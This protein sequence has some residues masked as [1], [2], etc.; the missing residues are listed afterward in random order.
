MKLEDTLAN[1]LPG[2]IGGAILSIPL[3]RLTQLFADSSGSVEHVPFFLRYSPEY[4][5][6]FIAV[7]VPLAGA[8]LSYALINDKPRLNYT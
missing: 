3:D 7:S 1:M 8:L 2:F 5:N 4:P 6:P